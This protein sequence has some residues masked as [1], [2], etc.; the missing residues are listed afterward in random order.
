MTATPDAETQRLLDAMSSQPTVD[1]SQV[2]VSALRA[3]MAMPQASVEAVGRV[4]EHSI[5]GG[6]QQ[7]LRLRLYAPAEPAAQRPAILYMHG[8]GFVLCDL[9]THDN[10]CRA[11]CNAA[12]ALVVSVDY[13]LAPEQPFPAAPEDA[14][15]ALLWLQAEAETLGVD[16][17]NI[18]VAGDSAGAN[19]AAVV[20]LMC[21]D[22]GSPLPARQWLLYPALDPACNTGSMQDFAEGYLLT[23]EQMRWFWSQYL[24]SAQAPSAYAQ[25][26]LASLDQLPPTTVITAE[27]DPLR[28][29]G[30]AFAEALRAAGNI[31]SYRCEP[32]QIH[33]FCSYLQGLPAARR[34]LEQL[35]RSLL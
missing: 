35:G 25:P 32:G 13:R 10:I 4:W 17:A 11:L 16:A 31:V 12:G 21:R 29:E 6:D 9:D 8:G 34:V 19:L 14:Y 28:D 20:S 24:P 1:F 2:P 33:G 5:R 26:L 23:R 30:Q 7:P 15:R 22:R 27:C 3:A 18:T